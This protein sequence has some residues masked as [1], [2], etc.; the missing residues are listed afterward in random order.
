MLVS[1]FLKPAVSWSQWPETLFFDSDY[2]ESI[3]NSKAAEGG[4]FT[5]LMKW[6]FW[7][8]CVVLAPCLA[9]KQS[10]RFIM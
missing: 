10:T 3:A 5:A 8:G 1:N 4:N 9:N 6:V 7:H 2:L